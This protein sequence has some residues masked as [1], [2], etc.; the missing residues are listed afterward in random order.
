MTSV[1][2]HL[3]PPP[4]RIGAGNLPAA[5]SRH[6]VR[7]EI[8]STSASFS[9]DNSSVD[10]LIVEGSRRSIADSFA[11]GRGEVELTFGRA[12][13]AHQFPKNSRPAGRDLACGRKEALCA[14]FSR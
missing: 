10:S 7:T 6:T 14:P 13:S 4:K 5:R 8:S 12:T 3:T 1:R 11:G 2:R 9:A